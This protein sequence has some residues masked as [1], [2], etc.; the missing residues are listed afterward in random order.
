MTIQLRLNHSTAR[1]HRAKVL[2]ADATNE[3]IVMQHPLITTAIATERSRHLRAE[4]R[5]AGR[6]ESARQGILD[7]L[8]SRRPRRRD[9]GSP[10][11]EPRT[12]V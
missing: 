8:L 1:R 9:C 2:A 4:G 11:L 10:C 7:R 12:A 6:R 5:A 3:G